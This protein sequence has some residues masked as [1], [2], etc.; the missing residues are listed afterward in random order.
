MH[1]VSQFSQQKLLGKD[2]TSSI[3]VLVWLILPAKTLHVVQL[4]VII[5]KSDFLILFANNLFIFH[6]NDIIEIS[7]KVAYQVY[8]CTILN[9]ESHF[10]FS[11]STENR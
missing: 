11:E 4:S 6:S 8:I 7:C 2:E 1:D 5:L 3:K 9:L 10:T